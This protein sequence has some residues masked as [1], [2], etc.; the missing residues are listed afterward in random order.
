MSET[1]IRQR[2]GGFFR[3]GTVTLAVML[4]G[5]LAAAP[6]AWAMTMA[7]TPQQGRPGSPVTVHMQGL[8]LPCEVRFDDQLVVP[9]SA[10]VPGADGSATVTFTVPAS[11]EPGG[12]QVTALSSGARRLEVSSVGFRVRGSAAAVPPSPTPSPRR[13]SPSPTRR[14]PSPTATATRASPSPSPSVTPA[15]DRAP[16]ERCPLQ[17]SMVRAITV[18]PE[19][20]TPGS[21]AVVT[22]SWAQPTNACPEAA[23]RLTLDGD[24]VGEP[25]TPGQA[26]TRVLV[27]IPESLSPGIH[28]VELRDADRND[29]LVANTVFEIRRD[30]P[31]W[32]LWLGLIAAVALLAVFGRRLL[33]PRLKALGP[34]LGILTL[35]MRKLLPWRRFGRRG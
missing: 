19:S 33:G 24:P 6:P 14:T 11:A 23:G 18:A 7:V 27:R 29:L 3:L 15:E 10:C 12:H 5:A 30:S 32:P 17:P 9:R 35:R 31:N 26:P 25:V 13:P 2:P 16:P 4:T 28:D 1:D 22:I 20:G 8:E 34:P 21:D